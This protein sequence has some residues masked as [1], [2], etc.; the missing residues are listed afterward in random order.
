LRIKEFPMFHQIFTFPADATAALLQL[1]LGEPDERDFLQWRKRLNYPDFAAGIPAFLAALLIF[2][3]AVVWWAQSDSLDDRYSKL[4]STALSEKNFPLAVVC[5]ERL[6]QERPGDQGV[7]LSLVAAYEGIGEEERAASLLSELA[8]SDA[9]GFQRAQL[10]I[11]R[12]QLRAVETVNIDDLRASEARLIRMRGHHDVEP[13]VSVLLAD[14]YLQTD[15]AAFV[16]KEPALRAA[17]ESVPTLQ[18]KLLQAEVQAQAITPELASI[19][20]GTLAK[21]FR[22]QL[23]ND[24]D[25]DIARRSLAQAQAIQGDYDAATVTVREGLALRPTDTRLKNMLVGLIFAKVQ[26]A[27][28]ARMPTPQLQELTRA[29]TALLKRH[30]P[31]S[32]MAAVQFGQMLVMVGDFAG[33]EKQ[34]RDAAE[35]LP[36]A[37]LDLAELLLKTGRKADAEREYELILKAHDAADPASRA[38]PQRLGMA[39]IAAARLGNYARAV[40]DL[41]KSA[42]TLPIA[43]TILIDT[44]VDWSDQVA[45]SDSHRS[46]ELLGEA[47]S[48]Q[49]YYAP[50]FSRLIN[51][52]NGSTE[53]AVEAR[54]FLGEM[55]SRN[56]APASAYLILGTDAARRNKREEALKYLEQAMR[57][58]PNAPAVLNNLA[59]TIAQGDVREDL[60]RALLLCDAALLLAPSDVHFRDTRGR[61]LAKLGRY[62][63]ALVDLEIGGRVMDGD[64]EF[65]AVIAEVYEKLGLMV[66]AASHRKRLQQLQQQP[67][68]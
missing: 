67:D 63:D 68:K 18:M 55:I 56:D 21:H 59:W 48:L 22:R 47:L 24:P 34:F 28:A 58:A 41:K 43:K 50:A 54:K 19:T 2:V 65:H 53:S 9:D 30:A 10:L 66:P 44:Y 5:L 38:S 29:S 6:A 36:A 64:P 39:G 62:R 26:A 61:I 40:D 16:T 12:R 42:P 3:S 35:K 31:L 32:D 27:V 23:T 37:R 20:A 15:R 4:A 57:L 13:E 60:G 25:D 49:P 17:A 46:M 14:L 1:L 11:V 45:K 33:G 8:P 51:Q 7:L 52:M